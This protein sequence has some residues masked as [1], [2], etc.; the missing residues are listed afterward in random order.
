MA[1]NVLDGF[2]VFEPNQRIEDWIGFVL[3]ENYIKLTSGTL[4]V[5]R[6]PEYVVVLFDR[7]GKRMMI[8][9]GK[10]D[11]P[12]RIGL[13]KSYSNAQRLTY[14]RNGRLLSEI[15]KIAGIGDGVCGQA[16]GKQA[17]VVQPTIIFDLGNITIMKGAKNGKEKDG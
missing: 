6:W 7:K 10:K 4:D 8:I 13:T 11:T 3:S 9:P 15:R 16:F 14:L 2:E 5:L 1:A 12:N 17:Q